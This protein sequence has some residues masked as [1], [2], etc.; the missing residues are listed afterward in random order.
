MYICTNHDVCIS[1]VVSVLATSHLP[2]QRSSYVEGVQ[3]TF[4]EMTETKN[5]KLPLGGVAQ[6]S[7]Y[8][9]HGVVYM[10][11]TVVR[12]LPKLRG[13]VGHSL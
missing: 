2:L 8:T 6:D 13:G 10:M 7:H 9:S 3:N 4:S 12:W 11:L 5:S 1:G